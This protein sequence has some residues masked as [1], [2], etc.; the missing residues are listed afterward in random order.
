MHIIHIYFIEFY[1]FIS[2]IFYVY[3]KEMKSQ[4]CM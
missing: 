3:F 1:I 4:Y 2:L